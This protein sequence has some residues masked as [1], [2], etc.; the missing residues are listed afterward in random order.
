[1]KKLVVYVLSYRAIEHLQAGSLVE[2]LRELHSIDNFE[3]H[4]VFH[5]NYSQDGSVEY[6]LNIKD[7]D[8]LLSTRNLLYTGGVNRG[9]QYIE[10]AYKPDYVILAS[11]DNYCPSGSYTRLL[12]FMESNPMVGIVQ[13]L[14]VSRRN[15][16]E[17]YSCGH[18]YV[19]GVFCRPVREMPKDD[20][21]L[22][23]LPSCSL[24]SSMIR[25]DV[26][27]K[28]GLLNEFFEIYYESSDLSFRVR[29]AG[30]D[31]ACCREALA[32]N[33][34]TVGSR[35]GNYHEAFYRWRNGLVLWHMHDSAKY[36]RMREAV[37]KV[38]KPLQQRFNAARYCTDCIEESTRKGIVEGLDI[39]AS[40]S[41]E[42]LK[43]Y[44][45]SISKFDKSSIIVLRQ[46][47][48]SS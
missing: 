41:P 1:M 36:T 35:T 9:L 30:F 12:N 22:Q 26:L 13:P 44:A 4:I 18:Q 14:V 33:E 5:D 42:K 25:V 28:I 40:V 20:S 46:G 39:C 16:T 48:L 6:A 21:V 17:I 3:T 32:Y 29:D 38:L 37:L 11:A 24:C 23:H 7:V 27:R 10:T 47:S 8:V 15:P 43:G 19:D 45:P 2:M 31:C 34:K